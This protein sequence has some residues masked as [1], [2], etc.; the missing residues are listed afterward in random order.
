MLDDQPFS[1]GV[2]SQEKVPVRPS[3]HDPWRR[4]VQ[5]NVNLR[6]AQA[7]ERVTNSEWYPRGLWRG[8]G[9]SCLS[10]GRIRR[11]ACV[12]NTLARDVLRSDP[13]RLLKTIMRELEGPIRTVERQRKREWFRSCGNAERSSDA[14]APCL[15]RGPGDPRADLTFVIEMECHRRV[16]DDGGHQQREEHKC[17]CPS[18]DVAHARNRQH[19]PKGATD[20]QRHHVHGW[21]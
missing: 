11:R 17:C 4:H 14:T 16:S 9:L 10:A 15:R 7:P 21:D 2:G 13:R 18:C 12:K 8:V 6:S 20:N 3:R 19:G 1:P 5:Y